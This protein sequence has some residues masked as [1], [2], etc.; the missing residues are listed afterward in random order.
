M[1][2]SGIAGPVIKLIGSKYKRYKDILY[3]LRFIYFLSRIKYFKT[4]VANLFLY[5]KSLF[6]PLASIVKLL[7][8]VIINL[9][10]LYV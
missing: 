2:I 8:L 9:I 7:L 1:D 5:L 3:K 10:L 6:N 4:S